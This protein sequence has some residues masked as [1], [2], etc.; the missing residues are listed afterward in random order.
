MTVKEII[1]L[2]ASFYPDP[3][4]VEEVIE[5]VGLEKK[6]KTRVN[7][8]SGGQKHRLAVGLAMVSNGKVV[9][10]DEP[11]TGLDPQA[12]RQ[13][14]DVVHQLKE[15]G[16]TVFLT[17]HYME[18]AEQLCDDLAIIDKGKVIASGSP[19]ELINRYFKE[20]AVEFTD[21]GFISEERKELEGLDPVKR[22]SY[23][24]EEEKIIIYTKEVPATI[25]SIFDYA[26]KKGK[27]VDD[28]V[29]RHATLEDVFLKL[30]G[31][32]IRE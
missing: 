7:S 17:T 19:Q 16:T 21:P 10:L 20:T 3:L 11:T 31:R 5:R 6:A 23:E 15:E 1:T 8:L 12:R 32:G 9:F 29:V 4:S 28:I 18:E 13:L 30:T 25:K 26:E 22:V 27:E 14:W 24:A 2:F